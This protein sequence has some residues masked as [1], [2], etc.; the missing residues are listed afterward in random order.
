MTYVVIYVDSTKHIVLIV[1]SDW[2]L[3]QGF[4]KL[5]ITLDELD[6]GNE[7]ELKNEE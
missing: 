2:S 7:M 4:C 1:C 6:V 3:L 5:K